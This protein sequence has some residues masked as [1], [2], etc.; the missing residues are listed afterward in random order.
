MLC[1]TLETIK[2]KGERDGSSLGE[3]GGITMIL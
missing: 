3:E 2:L 1:R